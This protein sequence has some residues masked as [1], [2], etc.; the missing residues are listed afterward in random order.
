MNANIEP[1]QLPREYNAT[2]H[3]VD[4]HLLEGRGDKTAFID[5]NGPTSYNQL[6]ER[7]NR[8]G[9]A[10]QTLGA[11]MESRVMMCMLDTIDFPALFWGA[12]KIWRSTHPCQHPA[13]R[14]RL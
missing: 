12:I 7:T 3:F 5:C 14:K 11:G 2:S 8:A 10:L 9:N 4:R 1:V 6:A 13:H